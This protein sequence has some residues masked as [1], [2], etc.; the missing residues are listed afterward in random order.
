M[1]KQLRNGDW[2][3]SPSEASALLQISYKT[4]QRWAE[5]NTITVWVGMNGHRRKVTKR[6]QIEF[7]QTPTGY[8]Y[9][10]RESIEKLASKIAA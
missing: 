2:Y 1:A 3:L 10:K 5:T 7:F 4:L 8:R 9:Y 6:I